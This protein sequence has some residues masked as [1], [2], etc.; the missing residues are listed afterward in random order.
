MWVLPSG[1]LSLAK[2]S[3]TFS[4]LLRSRI[5][6]SYRKYSCCF[7]RS[8]TRCV[9]PCARPGHRPP[10]FN[11]H[12]KRFGGVMPAS[13]GDCLVWLTQPIEKSQD[14][15]AAPR[16]AGCSRGDAELRKPRQSP[17]GRGRLSACLAAVGADCGHPDPRRQPDTAAAGGRTGACRGVHLP[18]VAGGGAGGLLLEVPLHLPRLRLPA[19]AR[20]CRGGNNAV[21]QA[22]ADST[23]DLGI[24]DQ[25]LEPFPKAIIKRRA[26]LQRSRHLQG[27][28][29]AGLC[30]EEC[31]H[32]AAAVLQL[33][34]VSDGCDD[35]ATARRLL[36]APGAAAACV[37]ASCC[38]K[39][40]RRRWLWR[41]TWRDMPAGEPEDRARSV[42]VC[43][44][45][46]SSDD[47]TE[48]HVSGHLHAAGRTTRRCPVR[49]SRSAQCA[50]TQQCRL[51]S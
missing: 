5:R 36:A 29:T 26:D 24:K 8:G 7:L 22:P 25:H 15:G 34:L 17:A 4:E 19:S 30:G 49:V 2:Y 16:A 51:K 23:T 45:A 37:Q 35:A 14:D 39:I 3:N 11:A 13:K 40:C 31:S 18:G 46:C 20:H 12:C 41:A 44:K 50:E 27:G 6:F 21:G 48:L 47:A 32:L 43:F 1:R 33:H 42:C 9:P 28:V 10:C 38:R